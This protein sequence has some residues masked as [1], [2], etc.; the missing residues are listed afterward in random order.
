MFRSL[1][2]VIHDATWRCHHL[3]VLIYTRREQARW[4]L[5]RGHVRSRR[6]SCRGAGL[7][8]LSLGGVVTGTAATLAMIVGVLALGNGI[9]WLVRSTRRSASVPR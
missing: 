7:L 3:P 2:I 9:D 6:Q 1:Q 4:F 8:Y 5:K